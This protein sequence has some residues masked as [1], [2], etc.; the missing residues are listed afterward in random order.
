M[1]LLIFSF[2]RNERMRIKLNDDASLL[3]C[4]QSEVF[5]FSLSS[6]QM[7]IQSLGAG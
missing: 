1:T 6:T 3:S 4:M 5:C 2:D 7:K